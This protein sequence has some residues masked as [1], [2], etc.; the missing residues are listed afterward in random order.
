MS[1]PTTPVVGEPGIV[2]LADQAAQSVRRAVQELELLENAVRDGACD[3][4]NP[5]AAR[6][7]LL[8][9][10]QVIDDQLHNALVALGE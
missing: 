6:D 10:I 7:S 2:Q 5:T 9:R 8:R 3:T 4:S 1:S